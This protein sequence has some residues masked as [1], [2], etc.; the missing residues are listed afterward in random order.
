MGDERLATEPVQRIAHEVRHLATEV[1]RELG[2]DTPF[3][4]DRIGPERFR[5]FCDGNGMGH[6]E[7]T[8]P[9]PAF[10]LPLSI[11]M[12]G[13]EPLNVPD[14]APAIAGRLRAAWVIRYDLEARLAHALLQVRTAFTGHGAASL[15][16][17]AILARPAVLDLTFL[18]NVF[19]PE[20]V[21][22][23]LDNGLHQAHVAIQL[24]GRASIPDVIS[25]FLGEQRNRDENAKRVRRMGAAALADRVALAAAD[26]S[27]EGRAAA[28]EAVLREGQT[29]I[30]SPPAAPM[31]WHANLR[32][33][34]GVIRVRGRPDDVNLWTGDRVELE[35]PIGGPKA[36]TLV[37]EMSAT[38]QWHPW[39]GACTIVEVDEAWGRWLRPSPITYFIDHDGLTMGLLGTEGR[40]Q[41]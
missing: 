13:D 35:R 33:I 15:G 36:R 34:N 29:V 1:A 31:A 24:P 30:S 27:G 17:R 23:A 6:I 9:F 14:L 8:V 20:V 40:C 41:G 39:L 11:P 28:I 25:A 26:A 7:L 10:D 3:G 19:V 4:R 18:S 16:V 21:C 2:S 38:A 37:G 5:A 32:Q 22:S 12:D